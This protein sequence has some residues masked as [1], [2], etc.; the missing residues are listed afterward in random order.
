MP[1]KAFLSFTLLAIF[2]CENNRSASSQPAT[3]SSRENRV[4]ETV[5]PY[6]QIGLIPLPE[7]YRR[8]ETAGFGQ[9][10]RQVKLKSSRTVFLYNGTPKRN[11]E[12]QYAVIDISTGNR[13]LQQCADAV[14][15]LKA[16]YL[17]NIRGF[18][19]ISFR[20]Y[21][22]KYHAFHPP[23]SRTRFDAYLQKVFGACGSASLS[24]QLH[25]VN[26]FA[27]IRPGDVLIRGG[28]P[29]H[30]VL[31]MDVAINDNNEKIFLL[32]QGFMPAQDMH[33]LLN[34]AEENGSPWYHAN[35]GPVVYTPEYTF[36]TNEL[37][38]W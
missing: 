25:P 17:F 30:A 36:R 18:D 12:A 21:A 16:E 7:G 5:N 26:D 4:M 3:A 33:V 15:R 31:V 32:A 9:Y 13:D 27:D 14:M 24:R 29:G 19:Q 2:A 34:P 28:F 11:Q 20:D 22:G 1:F 38:R 10:L 23:F 35:M 6:E 8:V 37:K